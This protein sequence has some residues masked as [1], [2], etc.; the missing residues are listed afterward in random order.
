M[1]KTSNGFEA[2]RGFAFENERNEKSRINC[3]FEPL[4]SSTEVERVKLTDLMAKNKKIL[5]AFC[6][7]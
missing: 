6:C 7:R 3:T 5:C 1:V 4:I 2:T